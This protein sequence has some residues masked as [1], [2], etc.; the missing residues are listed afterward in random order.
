[1]LKET[2]KRPY[3]F[4]F[5]GILKTDVNFCFIWQFA[6]VEKKSFSVL[7]FLN[8]KVFCFVSSN[9]LLVDKIWL[10]LVGNIRYILVLMFIDIY[11]NVNI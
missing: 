8:V 9:N 1:M 5:N 7:K 10:P 2:T 11:A 3:I 4:F 6:T